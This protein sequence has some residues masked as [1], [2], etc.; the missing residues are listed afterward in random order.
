MSSNTVLNNS[1]ALKKNMR[2]GSDLILFTDYFK[3]NI[4]KFDSTGAFNLKLNR[5]SRLFIDLRLI[6]KCKEPEFLNSIN[7]VQEFFEKALTCVKHSKKYGDGWWIAARS[8]LG[9]IQENSGMCLGYAKNG[10]KGSAMGQ[11]TIDDIIEIAK[12]LIE[13]G[14]EDPLIFEMLGI[15]TEGVG[16][17]WTS[18]ALSTILL[19]E[20]CS[21]S[22]RIILTLGIQS[23]MEYDIGDNTYNLLKNPF[24]GEPILFAPK[25]ILCNLPIASQLKDINYMSKD[26]EEVRKELNRL[27]SSTMKQGHVITKKIIRAHVLSDTSF[28]KT[29]FNEYNKSDI[30]P[31][32]FEMDTEKINVDSLASSVVTSSLK[33]GTLRQTINI[34]QKS[35]VDVT[36][37]EIND[38]FKN[39]IENNDLWKS[40]YNGKDNPSNETQIQPIYRTIAACICK[41]YDVDLSPE[42]NNGGGCVDFKFSKGWNSKILVELKLASNQKI[43]NGLKKQ[44]PKYMLAEETDRAYLLILNFDDDKKIEKIRVAYDEE[45][46][47]FKNKV[48]IL[49]INCKRKLSASKL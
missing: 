25:S 7:K 28:R 9:V 18:D 4:L 44:L 33:E 14:E 37:S 29:L 24:N 36:V 10:T 8:Y 34:S 27:I 6:K 11:G 19:D 48:S 26:N 22:S 47:E 13:M 39:N 21:Y 40:L 32:N 17:D 1:F 49:F 20:I 46:E 16:C 45:D 23:D 2:Q 12:E 3:V 30:E 31:Y 5:D 38:C 43:E 41:H 35:D 42:T 15:F